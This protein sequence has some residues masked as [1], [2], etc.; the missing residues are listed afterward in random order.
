MF[1]GLDVSGLHRHEHEHEIGAA[2]VRQV[3]VVLG[4]EIVDMVADRPGV[5]V[6]CV[7]PRLVGIGGDGPVV[8]HQ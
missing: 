3:A 2:N 1:H 4:G 8:I 5:C 6:E 7:F